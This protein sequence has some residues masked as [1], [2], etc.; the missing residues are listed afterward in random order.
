MTSV[1]V[2]I[3]DAVM[4]NTTKEKCYLFK[5]WIGIAAGSVIS[6]V[7]IA[8]GTERWLTA[9]IISVIVLSV[10]LAMHFVY[11]R[12]INSIDEEE[13][14]ELDRISNENKELTKRIDLLEND[15]KKIEQQNEYL[16][17]LWTETSA[18]S[19]AV[20]R[21]NASSRSVRPFY[22]KVHASIMQL[23]SLYAHPLHNCYSVYIYLY[24]GK[25]R[26]VQRIAAESKNPEIQQAVEKEPIS[27]DSVSDYYYAKCIIDKKKIFT[28]A[29]NAAIRKAFYWKDENDEALISQY[30]Q[31]AA[32]SYGLDDDMEFYIEVISYNGAVLRR[33]EDPDLS[34]FVKK[35]LAPLSS[36]V[37]SVNWHGLRKAMAA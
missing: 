12:R 1:L 24:D 26:R 13:K 28:L 30:T 15:K 2:R 4:I 20:Q 29:D 35:V 8:C 22:T 18:L 36:V 11:Q 6:I 37:R 23:V 10:S 17:G 9:L 19:Q 33:T 34:A 32:M 31:Y 14:S 25:T 16:L 21:V 27:I 5:E 3:V 7:G